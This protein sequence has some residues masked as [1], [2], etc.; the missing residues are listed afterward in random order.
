M[1]I[2]PAIDLRA[3]Q[4]VRLY[5]GNFNK[6]TIYDA[7]PIA[8]A[9]Q[10]E[11][12]GADWL[13]IVDLDG[14]KNPEQHQ[15]RLIKTIIQSTS[16]N[17]QTGGGIRTSQ[18][19]AELLD[20]GAKRVIIGSQA[21][22]NPA[23][24][25]QWWREFGS[26]Y[27]VLALDVNINKNQQAFVVTQGWECTSIFTLQEVINNYLSVDL[28]Y[29]LCTDIHCDGTLQGP[30]LELYKNLQ[31]QFPGL[32]IQ[33]SGGISCLGD[34]QKLKSYASGVIIG[35][36]LYESKFTLQEALVNIC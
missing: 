20:Y 30:N 7:E 33:A 34:L 36:A 1:Q 31:Q 9:K 16:L 23:E 19:I 11:N 24:V 12:Q 5:Q 21:I 15:R 29:I 2:Y 4:C 26:E 6:T 10:F 32:Y 14:A 25:K 8:L 27:L 22:K 18:D 17:I 3:A 28:K 35:R 13:H